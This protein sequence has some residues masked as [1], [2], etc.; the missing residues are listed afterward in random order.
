MEA[1]PDLT[2]RI[3]V[4]MENIFNNQERIFQKKLPGMENEIVKKSCNA[5]RK[6]TSGFWKC[7]IH[8]MLIFEGLIFPL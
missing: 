5:T 7:L 1:L 4:N 3:A 6:G 2:F 8:T